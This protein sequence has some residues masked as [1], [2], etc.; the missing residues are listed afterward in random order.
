MTADDGVFNVNGMIAHST[1]HYCLVQWADD[2]HSIMPLW[3]HT[4]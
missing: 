3:I 1:K 2:K 4:M